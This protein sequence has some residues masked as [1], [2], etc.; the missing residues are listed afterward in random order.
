MLE[1]YDAVVEHHRGI[2]FVSGGFQPERELW[3]EDTLIA[4]FDDSVVVTAVWH[5]GNSVSR[6]SAGRGPMTMVLVRTSAGYKISHL[7][8]ANYPTVG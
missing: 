6:R 2:G 7:H 1:G 3:L 5:F 4:D 8:M